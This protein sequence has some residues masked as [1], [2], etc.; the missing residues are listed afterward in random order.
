M[1][2][3]CTMTLVVAQPDH[4]KI[5]DLKVAYFTEKLQLTPSE[6][7]KFWK[8]YN[9]Y[10]AE[11]QS[12]KKSSKKPEGQK[13]SEMSDAQ[14]DQLINSTLDKK[15]KEAALQKKYFV[16]FKKV[17][18]PQKVVKLLYIEEQFRQFLFKKAQQKRK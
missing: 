15:E 1:I 11:R 5:K 18:P 4:S 16:E 13:I 17:L 6:T 14:I 10:E 7:D 12:L 2:F 8:I 3:F 9:Q